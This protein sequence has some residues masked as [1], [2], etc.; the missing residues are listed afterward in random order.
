MKIR[1][2]IIIT[3]VILIIII[4]KIIIIKYKN[5]SKKLYKLRKYDG[6]TQIKFIVELLFLYI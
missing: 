3:N 5:I 2:L 4:I 6:K 1:F